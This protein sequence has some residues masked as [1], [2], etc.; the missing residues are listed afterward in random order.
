MFRVCI[1]HFTQLWNSSGNQGHLCL[2]SQIRKPRFWQSFT[3]TALRIHHSSHL[4][5][6]IA[7]CGGKSQAQVCVIFFSPKP[8][9]LV[10]SCSKIHTNDATPTTVRV[11]YLGKSPYKELHE[12]SHIRRVIFSWVEKNRKNSPSDVI[13]TYWI[14]DSRMRWLL[15]QIKKQ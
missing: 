4:H 9:V 3:V 7:E 8:I 1:D 6:Q 2:F 11:S 12:R 10:L 5:I 13:S 15:T 14:R